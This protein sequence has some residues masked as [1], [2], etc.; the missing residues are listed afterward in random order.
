MEFVPVVSQERVQLRTIDQFVD[1]HLPQVVDGIVDERVL[2][3]LR[4]AVVSQFLK[5]RSKLW[6][7]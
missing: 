7:S 2:Q 6:K 4:H 1:V 3:L 5:V